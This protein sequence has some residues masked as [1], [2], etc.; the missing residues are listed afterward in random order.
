[1][2]VDQYSTE[3]KNKKGDATDKSSRFCTQALHNHTFHFGRGGN[4]SRLQKAA[5]LVF[6]DGHLVISISATILASK[7]LTRS[8]LVSKYTLSGSRNAIRSLTRSL[9]VYLC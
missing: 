5:I 2:P 3:R 8:I 1:M 4:S 9:F 7:Q 6:K